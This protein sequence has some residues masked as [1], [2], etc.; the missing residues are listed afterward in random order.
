MLKIK[1][2][3]HNNPKEWTL[4]VI[5]V[6][7]FAA[8][9]ILSPTRF[10]S[11]GNIQSM[12]FQLPEF[13]LIS[14]AMM[15]VIVTGGINLSVS[16]TAA[17]V[18]VITATVMISL[19][20]AGVSA[21]MTII[22]GI[23]AGLATA[24]IAGAINGF[25]VSII[26]VS[27]ILVTLGTMTLFDGIGLNLTKGSSISG[28]PDA[29]SFI[30][31]GYIFGIPF[32]MIIFIAVVIAAIIILEKTSWGTQVYM[33]GCNATATL[34]SGINIKKVLFKV[35]IFS[36]LM[37]ALAAIIMISRYNSAKVSYGSS[38]M[39]Q[40]V[41]AVVLGGTDISGGYGKVI[42]T[43]LAVAILQIVNSGL[44][45]LGMNGFFVEII[46]GLILIVVLTINFINSRQRE[47]GSIKK[48]HQSKI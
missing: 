41:A 40:A 45:I 17:L 35:Y 42:G 1:Q 18:Q 47:K 13:G 16:T 32:P 20:T 2:T 9:S 23:A 7:V 19:N 10:L 30:G 3:I 4:L 34:Y 36:A 29:Y 33:L 46:T 5:F 11:I 31:S 21:E 27:S 25:F 22:A 12:S 37:S 43:V 39:M 6:V 24:L 15:I 26:G 44:N 14:L 48:L 38:Y 8:L 28:F